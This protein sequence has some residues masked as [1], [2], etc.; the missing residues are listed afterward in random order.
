MKV[1]IYYGYFSSVEM[2]F[3]EVFGERKDIRISHV[4][5][6]PIGDTRYI[7]LSVFYEEV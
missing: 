6:T 2:K 4:R 3:N 5:Q 7:M 1:K